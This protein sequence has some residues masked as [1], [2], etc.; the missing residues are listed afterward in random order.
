MDI[1]RIR[2]TWDR[3]LDYIAFAGL[4]NN[5]IDLIQKRRFRH[6]EAEPDSYRKHLKEKSIK[7]CLLY[8]LPFAKLIQKLFCRQ[9][10]QPPPLLEESKSATW[11][12]SPYDSTD[13]WSVTTSSTSEED[14]KDFGYNETFEWMENYPGQKSMQIEVKMPGRTLSTNY[15]IAPQ[16]LVWDTSTGLFYAKIEVGSQIDTIN[17]GKLGSRNS[18]AN[19][20]GCVVEERTRGNKTIKVHTQTLYTT[21]P[22]HSD[23]AFTLEVLQKMISELI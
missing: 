14:V 10:S 20:I 2:I 17:L 4:I 5:A 19:F 12:S 1:A 9:H 18:P 23:C 8:M 3:I 22:Q 6:I 13:E 15:R 7:T 21:I 11:D 16:T